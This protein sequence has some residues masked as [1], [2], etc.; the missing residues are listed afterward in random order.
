MTIQVLPAQSVRRVTIDGY[1]VP[2]MAMQE[3]ASTGQWDVIYDNR[4]CVLAEDLSEVNRWLL[5]LA[6]VQAVAGGYSC[7]GENSVHLPN[8]HKV[9]VMCIESTTRGTQED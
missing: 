6:N 7:H 3:I 5:M 2:G 1:L 9:S 8:P 4:I